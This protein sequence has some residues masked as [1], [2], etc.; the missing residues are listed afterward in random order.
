MAA[1]DG[2]IVIYDDDQGLTV[3]F[4]WD[5]E[6]DGAL[7]AV[8]GRGQVALFGDRKAASNAIAISTHWSKLQRARGLVHNNDFT[9]GAKHIRIVSLKKR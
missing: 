6:C 5:S 7:C 9:D 3:P 1:A 8:G 2:Y 4:G